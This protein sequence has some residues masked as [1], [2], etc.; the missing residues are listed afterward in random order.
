MSVIAFAVLVVVTQAQYYG[1]PGYLGYGYGAPV[2]YGGY[3]GYGQVPVARLAAAPVAPVPVAR[4][5]A[6]VAPVREDAAYDPNPQYT[7]S[8]QVDDPVTGDSKAQTET[9]QG[10]VVQGSYTLIEPDGSRRTV[11]YT[12][13]PVSGFNAVVR[14]DGGVTSAPVAVPVGA[15]APVAVARTPVAAA[16]Y[17]TPL[18]V[19][20]GPVYVGHPYHSAYGVYGH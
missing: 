10:D 16:A 3:A 17:R 19:N 5:P 7:Y 11:D 2:A 4:A 18:A 13:D 14:K 8:Y 12:A 6:A 9:R 15:P 20:R 1:H